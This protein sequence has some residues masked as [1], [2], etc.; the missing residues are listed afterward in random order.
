M[1]SCFWTTQFQTCEVILKAVEH[2]ESKSWQQK[3]VTV[4]P[5]TVAYAG[6]LSIKEDSQEDQKFKAQL[7]ET[8]KV[9]TS[10]SCIRLCFNKQKQEEGH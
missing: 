8:F 4:N 9:E 5:S 3:Q 7:H 10:L 6:N 2:S 1:G